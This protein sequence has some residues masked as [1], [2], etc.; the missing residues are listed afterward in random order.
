VRKLK[1]AVVLPILQV[2]IASIL[3]LLA[4]R[5]PVPSGLD[6]YY[7]PTAWLACKGLNAPAIL[8]LV[9]LGGTWYFV[10]PIRIVGRGLFLVSV[11]VVWYFVGR[12]L[13]K[14]QAPGPVRGRHMARVVVMQLLLLVTGAFLL[15]GGLHEL[16]DPIPS[17]VGVVFTLAWAASLIFISGRTLLRVI[18]DAHRAT[19]PS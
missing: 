3:L 5:T 2:L 9:P 6:Y 19:R 16:G 13:D 11:V 14:Q 8:L 10:P 1:L 18:R 15:L 4:D 7:H 17:A 12:A